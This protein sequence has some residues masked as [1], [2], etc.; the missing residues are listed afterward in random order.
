MS[1]AVQDY[2]R[3]AKEEA[4]IY[5]ITSLASA[6]ALLSIF[7]TVTIHSLTGEGGAVAGVIALLC[8]SIAFS[9]TALFLETFGK[10]NLQKYDAVLDKCKLLN[11]QALNAYQSDRL[12]INEKIAKGEAEVARLKLLEQNSDN[13]S[14][15]LER[16]RDSLNF[17]PV[18]LA[19]TIAYTSKELVFWLKDVDK[20]KNRFQTQFLVMRVLI[21]VSVLLIAAAQ[22]IVNAVAPSAVARNSLNVSGVV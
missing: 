20:L 10:W 6:V 7:S 16:T 3:F 8:L 4:K 22:G 15:E 19:Q 17:M 11:K 14:A 12:A 9:I 2:S 5:S 18:A 21:A 1:D 13:A